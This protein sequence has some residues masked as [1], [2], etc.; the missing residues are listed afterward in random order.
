MGEQVSAKLVWVP[1]AFVRFNTHVKNTTGADLQLF[2]I[3]ASSGGMRNK[4]EPSF[5][6]C[7][8]LT[9]GATLN[10]T[11]FKSQPLDCDTKAIQVDETTLPHAM[12]KLGVRRPAVTSTT[13]KA[14]ES[15]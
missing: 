15:P 4:L 3:I 8:L 6:S 10:R 9:E 13:A 11:T 12:S 5:V 2:V 1:D 14:R 7:R